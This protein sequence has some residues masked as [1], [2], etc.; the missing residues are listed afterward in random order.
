[1][2]KD[3]EFI[4]VDDSLPKKSRD[5]EILREN[6]TT[7]TGYRYI[8]PSYGNTWIGEDGYIISANPVTGWREFNLNTLQE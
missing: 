7:E 5:V 4:D 6:G 2:T 1:M 3:E 8:S